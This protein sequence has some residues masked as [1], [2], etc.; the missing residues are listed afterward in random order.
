MTGRSS[1]DP[2]KVSQ[3]QSNTTITG[4]SGIGGGG[5]G[6]S[7]PILES[8]VLFDPETGHYHEGADSRPIHSVVVE[9]EW[10]S[11][12]PLSKTFTVTDVVVTSTMEVVVV[13]SAE[14][15]TG[16]S[17]DENEADSFLYRAV[18]GT[19]QFTVYGSALEGPVVGLYKAIYF[20]TDPT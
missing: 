2:A 16:R 11:T 9:L 12:P 14:A 10:G 17:Q 3:S 20:L 1:V 18:A 8:D 6:V 13:P 7:T 19:G 5:G 15:A 4:D